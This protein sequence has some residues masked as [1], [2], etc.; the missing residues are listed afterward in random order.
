MVQ[1]L[2]LKPIAPYPF[3]DAKGKP[4][5]MDPAT[6]ESRMLV[7]LPDDLPENITAIGIDNGIGIAAKAIH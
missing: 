5:V 7:Q 6:G 3:V 1:R 2:F 4:A